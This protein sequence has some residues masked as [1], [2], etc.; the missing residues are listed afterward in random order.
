M[1]FTCV[2]LASLSSRHTILVNSKQF[3]CVLRACRQLYA[4]WVVGGIGGEAAELA[5]G[6][7]EGRRD[8]RMNQSIHSHTNRQRETC[9]FARMALFSAIIA[10]LPTASGHAVGE[11]SL[12][13][14]DES[15][16][17]EL[18]RRR[19]GAGGGNCGGHPERRKRS[20]CVESARIGINLQPRE[21]A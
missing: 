11:S 15:T 1:R 4:V 16:N 18:A 9:W 3:R 2:T 10:F 21:K 20:E 13:V 7:G 8:L 19:R 6:V 17:A 12:R 14:C 5:D